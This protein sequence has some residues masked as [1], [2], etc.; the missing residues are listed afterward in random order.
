VLSQKD[1]LLA[2]NLTSSTGEQ[3]DFFQITGIRQTTPPL[4]LPDGY[5][6]SHLMGSVSPHEIE[7]L[8]DHRPG[9][10]TSAGNPAGMI[11]ERSGIP[12]P[13]GIVAAVLGIVITMQAIGGPAKR[14]VKK[15]RRPWWELSWAS[16]CPRIHPTPVHQ[17]DLQHEEEARCWR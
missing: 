5:G 2:W 6:A 10:P 1:G 8:M 3:P 17:L 15:S 4:I 13:P 7:A 12:C 16:C 14:W 11:C 9:N